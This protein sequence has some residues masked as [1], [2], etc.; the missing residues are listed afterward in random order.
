MKQPI[1]TTIQ[2]NLAKNNAAAILE[3]RTQKNW[4]SSISFWF[5]TISINDPNRKLKPDPNPKLKPD[6]ELNTDSNNF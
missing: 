2:R 3:K 1:T 6:P 5:T 4:Q